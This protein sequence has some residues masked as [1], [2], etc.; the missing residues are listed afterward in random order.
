MSTVL[1]DEKD[2]DAVVDYGIDWGPEMTPVTDTVISSGWVGESGITIDT[3][4]FDST[5]T[6]VWLSGGTPCQSYDL[7]NTITT[8][9]GRTLVQT[10]S[11]RVMDK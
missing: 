2:P 1:L 4:T 8:A 3:D 7:I 10:I 6:R 11:I 9:A 5:G